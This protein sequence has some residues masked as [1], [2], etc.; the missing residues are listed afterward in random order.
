M[1]FAER[2]KPA[3]FL[4]FDASEVLRAFGAI[5]RDDHPA[6]DDRVFT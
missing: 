3:R 5:G 2:A 4:G 6:A 1:S